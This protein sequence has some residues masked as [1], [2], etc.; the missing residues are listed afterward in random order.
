[1]ISMDIRDVYNLVCGKMCVI[2][3]ILPNIQLSCETFH[4][5]KRDGQGCPSKPTNR[6]T[7]P[8]FDAF[9]DWF[10]S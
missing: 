6:P 10:Q 3:F 5:K 9:G 7:V 8:Q 1:M 4:I 2:V